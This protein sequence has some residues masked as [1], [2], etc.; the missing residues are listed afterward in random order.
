MKIYYPL[1]IDIFVSDLNVYHAIDNAFMWFSNKGTN[2]WSILYFYI[3]LQYIFTLWINWSTPSAS[4]WNQSSIPHYK[5][6]GH[7]YI[8]ILNF[9][10]QWTGLEWIK[11]WIEQVIYIIIDQYTCNRSK[12]QLI[13]HYSIIIITR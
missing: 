9:K 5:H 4:W 7:L 12:G 8:L 10:Y 13:T 2:A 6:A 11:N 3:Y 1:M